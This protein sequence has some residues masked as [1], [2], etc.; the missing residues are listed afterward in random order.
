MARAD[1]RAFA[2][3]VAALFVIGAAVSVATFA[4]PPPSTAPAT[5]QPTRAFS[6][7]IMVSLPRSGPRRTQSEGIIDA[8]RL[9]VDEV[10]AHVNAGAVTYFIEV[11]VRNSAAEQGDWSPDLERANAQ[12]A[13]ADHS[14]VAYIGPATIAAARIVAP[15]AAGAGLAVITPTITHPGL[16]Q[17]GWDD[18]LYDA[19]HP[20]GANVFVRTIPSDAV[21]ARA[22]ARW[23]ID[24]TLSPAATGDDTWSKAFAQAI[25][26]APQTGTPFFYL[27][28][29]SA[30]V[31]ADRTR[32]LRDRPA[33]VEIGGA[34]SILSDAFIQRAGD[35]ARGV[36][37]AFAGRPAEQYSGSAA[38][39]LRS[40]L[41]TYV[42]APDPYAIFGYDA[43]RLV[44]DALS[45][46]E[47]SFTLDRAKVRDAAFATKDLDGAL[48]TWS[49][50]PNG[51]STY[52]KEQLYVV[53]ALPDGKLAWLWDAEIGP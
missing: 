17:P 22:M 35:A 45:R 41:N 2:I 28:G 53:R 32:S 46:S 52:A 40:F 23:A 3:V 29:L 19:V 27:G 26:T 7:R 42:I 12:A 36:V 47:Q 24:R 25:A 5:A 39:F 1:V 50:D 44:L 49:V 4:V 48:G 13:A 33:A 10:S 31:A 20:G 51:D 6:A 15:I 38:V 21:A 8:V 16:T 34:E 14:V 18:A 43:A 9:A 11:D 37:A 30:E